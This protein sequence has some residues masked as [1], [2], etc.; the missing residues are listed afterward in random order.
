M[1]NQN[2]VPT[3]VG[4][5]NNYIIGVNNNCKFDHNYS[6]NNNNLTNN[7]TTTEQQNNNKTTKKLILKSGPG[8]L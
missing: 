1:F 3:S 6:Y 8:A 4:P 7:R 2:P 5:S